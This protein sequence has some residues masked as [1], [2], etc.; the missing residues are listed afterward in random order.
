DNLPIT[1]TTSSGTTITNDRLV[2]ISS[3]TSNN[4]IGLNTQT[5]NS[6]SNHLNV[7]RLTNRTAITGSMF[8]GDNPS[9]RHI[10]PI[11]TST[12]SNINQPTSFQ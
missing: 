10:T 2:S 7:P 5:V 9:R 8:V 1:T 3:T 6:T 12:T 11:T 4:S